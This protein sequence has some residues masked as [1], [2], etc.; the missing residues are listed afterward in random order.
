[1]ARMSA[2]VMETP[3]FAFEA[4]A[5][6]SKKAVARIAFVDIKDPIKSVLNDCFRQFSAETV[7]ITGDVTSKLKK[8]KFDGCVLRLGPGAEAVMDFVRNS[9][10]NSRMVIYGIGGNAREALQYSKYGINAIFHEPL[11][12]QAALKLVR[13]TQVLVTHEFRRYI[14]IPVV[15]DVKVT[16]VEGASFSAMSQDVSTGGMSLRGAEAVSVGENV[17]ISFAL[18]TLPRISVRSAITWRS[19]QTRE[20]GIRFDAQDERRFR[21]KEW[22]SAFLEN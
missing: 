16:T 5:T 9:P 2:F 10:S 8:A 3:V 18:L 14:R 15:T 13:A 4:P 20:F 22:I 1:M 11:E 19:V 6:D 17:E 12:R 21:I 7:A